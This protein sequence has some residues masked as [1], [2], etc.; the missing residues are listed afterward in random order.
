[1]IR[2]V[3]N[4][5]RDEGVMIQCEKCEK[6]QHADCMGEPDVE[7]YMCELCDPRPLSKVGTCVNSV[8]PGL[9]VRWV[10]V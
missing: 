4:I 10:R 8:T 6:W 7:K 3:C 5:Y 2:C 9:S 1:M